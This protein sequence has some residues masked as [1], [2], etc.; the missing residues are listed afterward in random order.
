MS[1]T[2]WIP[3]DENE[4]LESDFVSRSLARMTE[5]AIAR[6]SGEPMLRRIGAK[7]LTADT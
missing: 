1:T 2:C 5:H 7:E 6:Q 4:H 3:A